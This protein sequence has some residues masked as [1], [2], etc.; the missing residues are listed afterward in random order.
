M[1]KVE[2]TESQVTVSWSL[3]RYDANK[4]HPILESSPFQQSHI[5]YCPKWLDQGQRPTLP[6]TLLCI[7]GLHTDFSVLQV[8]GVTGKL[9]MKRCRPVFIS[10]KPLFQGK[11]FKLCGFHVAL[12]GSP[13]LPH[14]S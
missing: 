10:R 6:F 8:E 4:S 14:S 12:T 1:V 13:F 11:G 9:L 3:S 5:S 7:P 2:E